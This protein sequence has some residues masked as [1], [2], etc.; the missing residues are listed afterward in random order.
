MSMEDCVGE[1]EREK[2]IKGSQEGDESLKAQQAKSNVIVLI[3]SRF[4]YSET[5]SK[6]GKLS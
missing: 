5:V 3:S 1:S 2:K 4:N 6:S